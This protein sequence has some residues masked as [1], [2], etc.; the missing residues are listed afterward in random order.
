M[1]EGMADD[2]V[3]LLVQ[4]AHCGER[5]TLTTAPTTSAASV[6]T[7]KCP[8]CQAENHGEF[9]AKL[10]FVAKGHQRRTPGEHE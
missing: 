10:M 2:P 8:F 4:C 6:Q 3:A 1:T 9:A 5:V 7:W